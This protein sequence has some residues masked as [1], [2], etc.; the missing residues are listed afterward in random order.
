[1]NKYSKHIV[2]LINCVCF[3]FLTHCITGSALA[4]LVALP[5]QVVCV[6]NTLRLKT[7]PTFKHPVTLDFV[8][9]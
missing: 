1:M 6:R 7:V 5:M 3:H 4:L 8:K 9:S 2:N